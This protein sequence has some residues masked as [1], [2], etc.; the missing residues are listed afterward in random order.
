MDNTGFYPFWIYM[1]VKNCHFR[2][3][4][5]DIT[6]FNLPQREKFCKIWNDKRKD[7]DGVHFFN[8]QKNKNF[9]KEEYIRLFSYY[10]IRDNNFSIF[11]IMKDSF[12]HYKDCEY[13]I[14][15]I[16]IIV[17]NDFMKLVKL[18]VKNKI[19]MKKFFETGKKLPLV[20]QCY[21]KGIIS[22]HSLLV[23][24]TVFKFFG[25]IDPNTLNLIDKEKYDFY[26]KIYDKYR[27]VVYSYLELDERTKWKEFLQGIIK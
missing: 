13:E 14:N 22:I 7:Q 26:E 9:S 23:F 16:Q 1:A 10:W 11:T 24:E 15:N 20:I 12:Q 5:Y 19:K 18:S 17:E 3:K 4:K 25:K 21:E 8:L 2:S 6:K 27:K